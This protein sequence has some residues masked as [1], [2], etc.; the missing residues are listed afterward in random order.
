MLSDLYSFAKF[1]S[2]IPVD[3]KKVK[4]DCSKSIY[5]TNMCFDLSFT[6]SGY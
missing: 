1:H 2:I 6:H 5:L 3:K 4:N